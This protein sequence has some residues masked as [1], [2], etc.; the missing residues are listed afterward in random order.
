MGPVWRVR[1]W[2]DCS[3]TSLADGLPPEMAQY[4][5]PEWRANETEYWANRDG[6]LDTFRGLW[7]AFAGGTVIASGKNSLAIFEAAELSGRHPFVTYVGGEDVADRIRKV[8]FPY[9]PTGPGAA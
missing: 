1:S 7:V 8:I 9:D 6:L 4:V 5:H 2:E 3:M